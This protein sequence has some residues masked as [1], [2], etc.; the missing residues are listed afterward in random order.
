MTR[1]RTTI[2]EEAGRS[3]YEALKTYIEACKRADKAR[4][5]SCRKCRTPKACAKAGTIPESSCAGACRACKALEA[6]DKAYAQA[7]AT[8]ERA[9]RGLRQRVPDRAEHSPRPLCR[10]P[11]SKKTS[12]G[13]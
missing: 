8:Y 4:R 3:A 7:E 12:R 1:R 2:P 10:G 13:S 6:R 9:T 5:A 11:G